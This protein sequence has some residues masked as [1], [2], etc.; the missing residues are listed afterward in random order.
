MIVGWSAEDEIAAIPVD[1][2][3]AI[4]P[5]DTKRL[6]Q[7][8][9][10]ICANCFA[11]APSSSIPADPLVVCDC[12]VPR[13]DTDVKFR[14]GRWQSACESCGRSRSGSHRLAEHGR[15]VSTDLRA[16]SDAGSG[17]RGPAW[18]F[19]DEQTINGV[20]SA[21][22]SFESANGYRW[23]ISVDL[24]GRP[25]MGEIHPYVLT[26]RSGL[27]ATPESLLPDEETRTR[28]RELIERGIQVKLAACMTGEESL[29]RARGSINFAT[30]VLEQL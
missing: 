15:W 26:F 4:C 13:I 7:E 3:H 28:L 16:L 17:Q 23:G 22:V 11:P 6:A 5:Y 2:R 25:A 19:T 30:R 12:R 21:H 8:Q 29:I 9:T 27:R 24:P 20:G 10:V 1:S 14:E 18:I